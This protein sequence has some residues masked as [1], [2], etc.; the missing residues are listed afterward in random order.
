MVAAGC[1]GRHGIIFT[2]VYFCKRNFFVAAA[3][4][5]F[6]SFVSTFYDGH[7]SAQMTGECA[8][9]TALKKY[10]GLWLLTKAVNL[11]RL[12]TFLSF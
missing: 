7:N 12:E 9:L 3:L 11:I 8:F 5:G 1:G 2:L 4:F 6:F 10:L